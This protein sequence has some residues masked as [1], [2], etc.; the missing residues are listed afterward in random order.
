M[1]DQR[2][3]T[4]LE[5]MMVVCVVGVLTMIAMTEYNKIHNR[6]YVGAAMSDVQILRKALAMYDAEWGAFPQA[7]AG[8]ALALCAVLNDPF[9]QPYINAV[10]GDNFISF[11]YAPPLPGDEYGDYSITVICKDH[12]RTQII[13]HST[14]QIDMVHTN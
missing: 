1:T 2:G 8:S 4:L 5:L 3:Y 11:D 12:Y 6:A 10:P 7:A 9:N 13:V 14:S